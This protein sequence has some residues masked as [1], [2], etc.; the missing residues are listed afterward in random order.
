M[1][2]VSCPSIRYILEHTLHSK[3]SDILYA[4]IIINSDV[5]CYI[6][7]MIAVSNKIEINMAVNIILFLKEKT[8]MEKS[9]SVL[10]RISTIIVK[11]ISFQTIERKEP[12]AYKFAR[13]E[14]VI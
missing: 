13:S 7:G 6:D 12:E 9:T 2:L 4:T 1:S 14:S 8:Y 11:L 5:H 10:L 3:S